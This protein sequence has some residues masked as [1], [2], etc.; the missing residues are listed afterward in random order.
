MI[1]FDAH[2]KAN[3]S[4]LRANKATLNTKT[5]AISIPVVANIEKT[6][7]S[8]TITG[9][10]SDPKVSVSSKYLEQKLE[11]AVTKGLE[12]VLNKKSG[13]TDEKT[14]KKIDDAKE[15]LKGIK[16]LF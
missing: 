1:N 16:G 9:T 3:K 11:K 6:D 4:E 2:M 15:I 7:I 8:G 14:N 13:S 10:T 5:A 12:K